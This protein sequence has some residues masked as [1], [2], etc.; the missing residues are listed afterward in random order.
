[1]KQLEGQRVLVVGGG[2]N[3]GAAIARAA[4]EAGAEVVVGARDVRRA[5]DVAAGLPGAATYVVRRTSRPG[6]PAPRPACAST[7]RTR[8]RSAWPWRR[9]AGSTTSS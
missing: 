1:M 4:A 6:S 7:S 5:Q 3:L 2:R 8:S 9:S